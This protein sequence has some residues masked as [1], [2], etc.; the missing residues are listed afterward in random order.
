MQTDPEKKGGVIEIMIKTWIL[1]D[2]DDLSFADA[3]E[4]QPSQR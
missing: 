2:L 3:G 1:S 4:W